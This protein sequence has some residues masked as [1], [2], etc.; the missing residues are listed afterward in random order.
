MKEKAWAVCDNYLK[1]LNDSQVEKES[2]IIFQAPD[3]LKFYR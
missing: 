2:N 1:M 3:T